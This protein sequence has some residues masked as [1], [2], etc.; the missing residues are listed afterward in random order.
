MRKRL[1]AVGA[2]A[3]AVAVLSGCGG[4]SGSTASP[5]EDPAQVMKAVVS[6]ELAGEQAF[7]YSMLVREQRKVV[8]S[9]LYKSCSP[10]AKMQASDVS[11][12]VL[13]VHD[14]SFTVPALGQTKTK[15]VKYKIDFHDGTDPIVSTGHLIAEEGHWRWT[16]SPSSFD[17]FSS[18][19]CP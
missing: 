12:A 4:S 15:A 6:H 11:V 8:S 18:G 13:G 19:S 1:T 14:E 5:K 10:G 17:S 2:I 3:A 16:L 7:T 9:T